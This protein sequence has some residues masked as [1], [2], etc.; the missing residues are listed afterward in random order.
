MPGGSLAD[1]MGREP[2]APARAMEIVSAVLDALGEAHRLGI[3]HRD[4][5]PS[6]V[7]FDDVGTARLGDFGAAHLGDLSSTATAGAIGTFAYMSPEQRL[8]KPATV[9]S[10]LYGAG[11]MLYELLTGEAADPAR[12]GQLDPPPSACH[13]DLGSDHD[14]AVARLLAEDPAARPPD[15]FEARRGLRAL[16]WSTRLPE[17]SAQSTRPRTDRPPPPTDAQR[18]AAPLS[19]HDGRDTAW[20]RHD[21]WSAR[22]VLVMAGSPETLERA[23]AFARAGHAALPT[24]LRV[25]AQSGQ[26]WVA[27]PLGRALADEPRALSPGHIGRLEEALRALREAGGAHGAIDADHLYFHDGEFTLAFP[28]DA[29]GGVEQAEARDRQA[30]ARLASG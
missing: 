20:R 4:V 28:R 10:D 17:R 24:V 22:D 15:A 3:L 1:M 18:L 27:P 6:N 2:V 23:R 11:A 29:A 16:R 13:P 12:N 8:G 19:A 9:A 25:D 21:L 14:V 7:L 5:K 26:V 30:L